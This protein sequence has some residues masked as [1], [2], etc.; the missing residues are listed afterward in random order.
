MGNTNK[1]LFGVAIIFLMM[2]LMISTV[3]AVK[4]LTSV[5]SDVGFSVEPTLKSAIRTGMD[6]EFEVHV[7]NI[8]NGMPVTSGISCYMHLY[9]EDGNHIYE[10][11]DHTVNHDFD[12]AFDLD[13]GN[14]T[15]RGEYQ[16]K[17]QCNSSEGGAVEMFFIVNDIGEELGTAHSIKFNSAMAFMMILF[18]M[19]FGGIITIPNYTGKLATYFLAHILFIAGTFSMWQFNQGYTTHFVAL[20]GVWRVMFY[21]ST[22]ALFPAI[23]MAVAGMIVYFTTG[24]EVQRLIDKG[25]PEAEAHRRQG[26]KYK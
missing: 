3:S 24:K 18:L 25:M 20:A 21:F 11:V 19:C 17:F 5:A 1:H 10:G 9:Q 22:I 13:G 23:I 8:S 12:Y 4:P 7:F 14:F 6:H 15:E 26:R 2:I 16:A